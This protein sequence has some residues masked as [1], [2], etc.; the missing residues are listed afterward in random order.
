[1]ARSPN[2]GTQWRPK[3]TNNSNLT[4]SRL[5]K[6]ERRSSSCSSS[7]GSPAS[8]LDL[9]HQRTN[10]CIGT[11]PSLSEDFGRLNLFHFIVLFPSPLPTITRSNRESLFNTEF[12]F[13]SREESQLGFLINREKVQ[14]T[15]SPVCC[16]RA[17]GLCLIFL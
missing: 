13:K 7:D 11:A 4:P 14:R 17:T 3:L 5:R 6:G 12:H 8:S 15:P 9:L 10:N 16:A 2:D 1:V